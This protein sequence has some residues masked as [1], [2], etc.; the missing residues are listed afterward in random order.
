MRSETAKGPDHAD[1]V[2]QRV[3]A[4]GRLAPN[5]AKIWC[6]DGVDAIT[7]ETRIATNAA[8]WDAR[9]PVHVA[10]EF[11]RRNPLDWF[12]DVEWADLGNLE[13][14]DVLHLQC[15]IGTETHA[16]AGKGARAVGLDISQESVRYARRLAAEANLDIE[17]VQGDVRHADKALDGRRFD[18]V[19][20]GKG[21]LC[22]VPDLDEWASTIARLLRPDGLLYLVEFH[23]LLASLG[24]VPTTEGDN[25][26]LHYD[27]L[28]GRGAVERDST[29]TYTDGP[30]VDGVRTS[31]EW[32]HGIGEVV[33]AT[34]DAGLHLGGLRELDEIPWRRWPDMIRTDSGWWRLPDS[35]PRVP[36]LYALRAHCP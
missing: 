17:F 25:F 35:A 32:M 22:Y 31:Y 9:T 30:A 8:N 4:S 27:Y 5:R 16:L 1:L 34:L 28:G 6:H 26:V 12:C 14:R 15:H 7:D 3:C 36:L 33:Q 10:S 13:G 20:T 23:P 24:L 18:V 29:H 19:Y 2:R 11:Y 21:S